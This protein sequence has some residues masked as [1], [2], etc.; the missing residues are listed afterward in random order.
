[1]SNLIHSHLLWPLGAL[2]QAGVDRNRLVGPVALQRGP[3]DPISL[4][5]LTIELQDAETQ[6]SVTG[7]R[8]L[9]YRTADDSLLGEVASGGPTVEIDDVGFYG[10]G[11]SG[12]VV[13]VLKAGYRPARVTAA[14]TPTGALVSVQLIP[15]VVYVS[16]TTLDP[17]VVVLDD[18]ALTIEVTETIE[19]VDLYSYLI[20]QWIADADLPSTPF[21]AIARSDSS[22]EVRGG[23]DMLD[24][25]SR[26]FVRS[27]GWSVVNT[28]GV[29]TAIYANVTTLGSIDGAEIV[30]YQQEDGGTVSAFG[31][32][33]VD[34]SILVYSDPDGDGTPTLDV[35]DYLRVL[36]RTYGR[37]YDEA[38]VLDVNGV[39]ELDADSYPVA[40]TTATDAKIVANDA[41][42][43]ASAPYTGMSL[44][45]EASPVNR[46][47]GGDT[48]PYSNTL[49]ANGGTPSQV[50]TWFQRQR[51]LAA[52]LGSG[53]QVVSGLDTGA[54]LEFV[55]DEL[56]SRRVDSR[57]AFV[58]DVPGANLSSMTL[59][60]DDGD[61]NAYPDY[62]TVTVTFSANLLSGG[63]GKWQ[64]FTS[65][66]YPG[67][68]P[69]AVT[70]ADGATVH[71]DGSLTANVSFAYDH[72][73][74]GD[75]AVTAVAVNAGVARYAIATG[76]ITSSGLGLSLSA[77]DEND[78]VYDDTDTVST[79]IDGTTKRITLGA[80]VSTTSPRSIYVAWIQWLDTLTGLRFAQAF[81][82]DGGRTVGGRTGAPKY[83]LENGWQVASDH[84]AT[85][86]GTGSLFATSGNPLVNTGSGPVTF[87]NIASVD[88]ELLT[89]SAIGQSVAAGVARIEVDV[90]QL[91]HERGLT[92]TQTT[93]V[94]EVDGVVTKQVTA[95]GGVTRTIQKSGSTVTVTGD[96]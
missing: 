8:V 27:A 74:N 17:G 39:T 90:D 69:T 46:T 59:T 30:R 38:D 67:A 57:G 63:T 6:G 52:V 72:A 50:Y 36:V 19:A 7:A 15:D 79:S 24:D 25:T 61:E 78:T 91:R 1:M 16:G 93:T 44:T 58:D 75:L 21:P 83:V 26:A 47:V 29:T 92:G 76:T 94:T 86:D 18:V 9:A 65:A 42:V 85:I 5:T 64:L 77:D 2:G 10:A 28:S 20:D 3:D 51:R 60:D 12:L 49:D 96:G 81:S 48:S 34:R 80:A 40:L 56:Y 71:D 70:D 84:D 41:T 55:G 22:Y 11:E 4:S 23:W 14:Q 73:T 87:N 88:A 45:Y 89:T 35:R 37:T 82:I 54:I 95:I 53:A 32:G 31:A 13:V 43:D 33:P 62:P 68:S 66:T